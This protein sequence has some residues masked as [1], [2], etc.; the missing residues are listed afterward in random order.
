[1]LFTIAA[2]LKGAPLVK[3]RLDSS[4]ILMGNLT[5]LHLEVTQDKGIPGGFPILSGKPDNKGYI[6]VCGD[7]VELRTDY[8][9]DTIEV[10]SGKIQINYDIPVQ[11][12][13]SGFYRLP[14]FL[15][16]C[17]RDSAHSNAVSLK[18]LPVAVTADAQISDYAPPAEP[19]GKSIFDNLPDWMLDYWWIIL[20]IICLVSAIIW[21]YIRY[22]SKGF[23]IPPKPEPLPYEV[24]LLE[25]KKL[26][27]L[28][29]WEQGLEKEYFT[30]LTDIL[31]LY[32]DKRFDINAIEMTTP[33]IIE[34]LNENQSI[35]SQREYIKRILDIAD[36]V[37]FAKVRPLP[38]DNIAAY[39][40]AWKFVEETKPT[41]EEIEA[42]KASFKGDLNI[43]NQQS[44]TKPNIKK[45]L[46]INRKPT[47][48]RKKG[49]RR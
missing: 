41:P 48:F 21:A 47:R 2:D 4:V 18:V 20:L 42:Y 16:V 13:D 9:R 1:M 33:Q 26:K 43:E 28:N 11:S 29:L 40:S 25:L 7:S 44:K 35:K 17:G 49:G 32:L 45:R 34:K 6:G 46:K 36:F 30:R 24:A 12:F 3:A 37:K 5:R 10:G 15:Y 23:I 19:E 31:R 14:S 8:K 27:A 38:E 39:D 22:R